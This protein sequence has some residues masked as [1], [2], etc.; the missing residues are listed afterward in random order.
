MTK[1]LPLGE[2]MS[3]NIKNYFQYL[4]DRIGSASETDQRLRFLGFAG[5]FVFHYKIFRPN[6]DQ[7][8]FKLIYQ[9]HKIV[10]VVHIFGN[11]YW[12]PSDFFESQ[13][14]KLVQLLGK[15]DVLQSRQASLKKIQDNLPQYAQRK[16]GGKRF[17]YV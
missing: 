5:L 2:E 16:M 13:V 6:V 9:M 10:P 4:K 1:N 17:D 14:P 8:Y 15:S 7:K 3:V 12:S 11:V